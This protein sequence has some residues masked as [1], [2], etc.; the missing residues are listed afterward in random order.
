MKYIIKTAIFFYIHF[1]FLS[2]SSSSINDT[3]NQQN[4]QSNELAKIVS[5]TTSG[6][7]NKYTFSVGIMNYPEAEPS[8]YQ[9]EESLFLV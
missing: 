9:A 4:E 7:E 3:K 8:R 1:L 2:C 5:V 6:S